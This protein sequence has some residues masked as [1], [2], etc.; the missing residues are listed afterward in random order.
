MRTLLVCLLCLIS[1]PLLAAPPTVSV[2][3]VT[4]VCQPATTAS[5]DYQGRYQD[6][7]RGSYAATISYQTLS[8]QPLVTVKF[9]HGMNEGIQGWASAATPPYVVNLYD[10][11]N[12]GKFW[13]TAT[14]TP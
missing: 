12:G 11:N 1:A 9:C 2:N 14:I 4:F 5:A 3:G 13:A 7:F 6:N 10:T 8:G